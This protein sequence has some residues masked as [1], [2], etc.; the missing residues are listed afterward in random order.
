LLV[1]V[2]NIFT[3]DLVHLIFKMYLF[4]VIIGTIFK[5]Q[6]QKPS[7][8]QELV[9]DNPMVPSQPKTNYTSDKDTLILEDE[10]ARVH[11]VPS[12]GCGMSVNSVVNGVICA[13][14]G[15]P[16][17]LGKFEVDDVLWA[18]PKPCVWPAKRESD[19]EMVNQLIILDKS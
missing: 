18:T 17:I 11:L 19:V 2:F 3:L 10:T 16:T 5:Q 1:S 8:L 4:P 7:I 6:P 14:K 15:K 9:E 13:V 12:K